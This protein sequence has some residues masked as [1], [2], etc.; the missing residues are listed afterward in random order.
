MH[1]DKPVMDL[2]T[3]FRRPTPIQSVAWPILLQG[4]DCVGLAKTGSGKTLAYSLPGIMHLR[5][6]KKVE[7]GEGWGSA[8]VHVGSQPRAARHC[9]SNFFS[10]HR[11]PATNLPPQASLFISLLRSEYLRLDV[12]VIEGFIMRKF[13]VLLKGPMLRPGRSCDG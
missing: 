13:S 10:Q 12:C 2:L 1:F 11:S 3:K 9:C 7:E 6:Q 5:A 8:A 4:H